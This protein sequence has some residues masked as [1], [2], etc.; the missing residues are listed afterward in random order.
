MICIFCDN[1]KSNYYF[2]TSVIIILIKFIIE[3]GININIKDKYVL[4]TILID[5]ICVIV[6]IPLFFL[7]PIITI[8]LILIVSLCKCCYRIT[9]IKNII[10]K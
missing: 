9:S 2:G 1:T 5:F 6:F 8:I 7:N 4:K 10:I 3:M